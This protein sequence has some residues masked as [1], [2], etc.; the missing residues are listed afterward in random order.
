MFCVQCSEDK[1]IF[2]KHVTSSFRINSR[3][4]C[5]FSAGVLDGKTIAGICVGAL[6]VLVIA[7]TVIVVRCCKGNIHCKGRLMLLLQIALQTEINVLC[8]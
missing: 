4:V 3:M 8:S 7:I 5:V 6:T 2:L 1:L